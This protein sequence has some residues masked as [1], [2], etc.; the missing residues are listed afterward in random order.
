[1][2]ALFA[3][4]DTAAGRRMLGFLKSALFR[5]LPKAC[6]FQTL[7]QGDGWSQLTVG[8]NQ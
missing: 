2:S 8:S 7:A 5:T 6:Q 4:V 3:F 1:V